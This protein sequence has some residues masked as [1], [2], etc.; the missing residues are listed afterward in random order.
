MKTIKFALSFVLAVYSLS[1][2][3]CGSAEK[4]YRLKPQQKSAECSSKY[5]HHCYEEIDPY[6]ANFD[7]SSLIHIEN[8]NDAERIRGN[9]INYFWTEEGWPGDK[10][11]VNVEYDI[12]LPKWAVSKNIRRVD[13]MD[14]EMDY[15]MHSYVYHLHPKVSL[16]RL[17]IIQHGHT[18]DFGSYRI[19][20]VTNYFLDKGF[21]VMAYMMPLKGEDNSRTAY[22]VP[23]HGTVNLS[24]HDHMSE[25]LENSRGSFIRFFIEPVIVGINYSQ[26]KY[27]YLDINM[28]GLSGGGWT[29]NICAA[30]DP[31]ISYSFPTAGSS[32]LYLRH[33]PCPNGS[34]GDAEQWWPPL[35]EEIASWPDIYILGGY[36]QGRRQVLVLNQYDNCCFGGINY[37]TYLPYVEDA[38]ENLGSGSFQ[39]YLDKSHCVHMISDIVCNE[40]IYP[41]ISQR[42]VKPDLTKVA[43]KVPFKMPQLNRP[44]FPDRTVDIRDYGAVSDGK[45]LNT[46][47]I[48]KAIESCAKSGGGRVLVP[49]G[50]WLTGAVHLKSNIELYLDRDA[51]LRFSTNPKDYLPVVFTRWAGFEC[52]NYS[53]LIYARDCENIAVTGQGNL[54]GQGKPWWDWFKEQKRMSVELLEMGRTNVPV[55]ERVFGS[56]DKPL[57]PQFLSPI[58]CRNVL[59]E[60]ITLN[61]GPF[62]TIQ[63]IYCENVIIRGVG[64]SNDGP[65]NDGI[66]IDSCRNV[67]VE[68]CTLDTGDDCV[69]LKSGINEDGRR[70]GRPTENVVVRQCLMKRGHGGVVIGSEM[71]GGVRN[72]LAHNC[73]FDG[74]DIGIRLKSARGRGGVVE[75]VWFRDIEMDNICGAAISLNTMYKAWAATGSGKAPVFRNIRIRNVTCK[76]ADAA[77]TIGGLAEQPIENVILEQVSIAANTGLV[78]TD[79]NG[80]KLSGVTI[81]A[82]G[83]QAFQIKNC[84]NVVQ[85]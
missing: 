24:N 52:Y 60:G 73:F 9:I 26:K 54:D 7:V 11:P 4:C 37:Q 59:I 49:A 58:N 20:E 15:R 44:V 74:T 48:A 62:W 1:L 5:D 47:A 8:A 43:A 33:G 2:F 76:Q 41:L 85:K 66:N 61:G 71:S 69:A 16:N 45:T 53:P 68:H 30:I 79:V 34:L 67:L 12:P 77:V 3:G 46:Q 23:G 38:V 18:D 14:I 55:E 51:V 19:G 84:Y 83:G 28:I 57:R 50:I 75:N 31:R 39:I 17:L 80:L 13:K 81:D 21:S 6:Y 25:V 65:N 42:Q 64:I 27:N 35:Y 72:V 32:P 36:G 82:A 29:T 78:A 40:V 70:V 63:C 10:M 56:P 22:D